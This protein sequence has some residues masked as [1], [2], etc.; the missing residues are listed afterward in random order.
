MK[1]RYK[2]KKEKIIAGIFMGLFMSTSSVT[3]AILF[4]GN[5][6][7]A[8]IRMF[9]FPL[10]IALIFTNNISI[11]LTF[12]WLNEIYFG[13]DGQWLSVGIIPARG[14]LLLLTIGV[15][16]IINNE[17]T[18][19]IIKKKMSIKVLFY[20]IIFPIVLMMY[21]IFIK[22]INLN[23]CLRDMMRF[24][25]LL[26]F[27]PLTYLIKKN[28]NL[29][30]GWQI[31]SGVVLAILIADMAIDP[32]GLKNL[33][34]YNW[35][36]N[37]NIEGRIFRAD[38][39]TV[40]DNYTRMTT[41]V[42][43]LLL[44]NIFI[45][46]I[47]YLDKSKNTVRKNVSL[48]LSAISLFPFVLVALRG[49]LVSILII[50]LI[51]IMIKILVLKSEDVNYYIRSIFNLFILFLILSLFSYIMTIKLVPIEISENWN[52][53]KNNDIYE[54]F[55]PLRIEQTEIMINY[56]LKEPFLGH[57]IGAPIPGYSRTGIEDDL[58]FEVQY[59]MVLYRLGIIGFT[60]LMVPFI[61]LIKETLKTL[62]R[63]EKYLNNNIVKMKLAVGFAMIA[64]LISSFTNPYFASVMT[65]F[66]F[67]LFLAC[68]YEIKFHHLNNN[69][70]IN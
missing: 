21:S 61:W 45:G 10:L 9:I 8:I 39:W 29:F 34:I 36:Y 58:R 37:G 70:A 63:E 35:F 4:P 12:A 54:V 38:L 25:A 43:L 40:G 27:F 53:L 7:I 20:S 2:E 66:F 48:I 32:T 3:L 56:W 67:A 59:P 42:I 5:Q 64:P 18:K 47:Y 31:S 50:F 22:N 65:P 23:N 69:R 13:V 17:Y 57:G 33:L 41:T 26:I 55:N 24:S 68:D 62:L 49:P 46:V 14:L 1:I 6:F 44:I 52:I 16:F 30:L 11:G 51:I 19:T 28:Y 15:F 60:I